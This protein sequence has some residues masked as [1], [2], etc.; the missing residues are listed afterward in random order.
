MRQ[1]NLVK[2]KTLASSA[3]VAEDFGD[4]VITLV[5]KMH[6]DTEKRLRQLFE[7]PGY[8]L[9]A[10]LPDEGNPAAR[11]RIIIN[12]I[13][14]KYNPLF[15]KWGTFAVKRMVSRTAKHSERALRGSL[16]DVG[17]S[18]KLD[19]G[20]MNDRLREIVTASSNEAAGLIK[21]IPEKYLADV[22]G[23]TMR[24]IT[25]GTGLKALVPY[26]RT[27][28]GQSVR[29]ARFVA[30]DQ[31]RKVFEAV[32]AERCQALGIAEFEWV[33]SGRSGK[34][35]RE[36]H[37]AP[38]DESVDGHPGLNGGIFRYD[39]PPYIGEMYGRAVYGLPGTLPGCHC[40][41]RPVVFKPKENSDGRTKSKPGR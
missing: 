33:H 37:K 34:H 36:L 30:G 9:D 27:Q 24:S 19:T 12:E 7:H 40:K 26:M 10:A 8:A 15:R 14:D 23:A 16:R 20:L 1:T 11:A 39:T 29:K 38:P 3:G 6:E 13:R 17:E 32:N 31:T 22:S 4:T 21:T 25:G 28:Y 35:A 18:M 41:A 5:R 2:G